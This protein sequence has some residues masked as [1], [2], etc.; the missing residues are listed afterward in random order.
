MAMF[1]DIQRYYIEGHK[2]EV[3]E[4]LRELNAE[5][6]T[7]IEA[8]SD[9]VPR[10]RR[11]QE[12]LNAI[13]PQYRFEITNGP[14]E[15]AA[16]AFPAA[17]LHRQQESDGSQITVSVVPK[18]RDAA[19]DR[20]ILLNTVFRFP[21]TQSGQE[22]AESF[23]MFLEYGYPTEVGPEY[24]ATLNIDAPGGIG[25]ELGPGHLKIQSAP[26]DSP[27]DIDARLLVYGE[28]E[29]RIASLPVRFDA[30][31]AGQ[32]GR[33]VYG[34]DQTG[35]IK[36]TIRW[37][38]S[39]GR[40]DLNVQ[41]IPVEQQA[42]ASLL[43]PL[44][45]AHSLRRPNRVALAIS[46]NEVVPPLIVPD[47]DLVSDTYLAIVEQVARIQSETNTYFPMPNAV[48]SE[49]VAIISRI[50]RLLDGES[51]AIRPEIKEVTLQNPAPDEWR[52]SGDATVSVGY[53]AEFSE[54]LM[55][56]QIPLGTCFL[57]MSPVTVRIDDLPTGTRVRID[58]LEDTQASLRRGTHS[59][60]APPGMA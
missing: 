26:S 28:G 52:P 59:A 29:S 27:I 9:A 56:E 46:G 48:D 8:V 60:F 38:A 41:I 42:P 18:Y 23:R 12:R 17:M 53:E 51:L 4:L 19:R 10:L 1:P 6:N 24:L 2:D 50:V 39:D 44:R 54:T 15:A 47:M 13:D 3:I 7:A 57:T 55:G 16:V 22:A 30:G 40:V 31:H 25:G 43:L 33:V 11:I 58:P 49:D 34:Q 20:P 35:L 32:A 36:L 5:R 21:D 37:N 45:L 14:A